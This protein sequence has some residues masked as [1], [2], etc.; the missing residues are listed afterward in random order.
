MAVRKQQASHVL[1][2]LTSFVLRCRPLLRL[3]PAP[4][5]RRQAE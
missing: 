3:Q 5:P 4:K 1:T 2:S